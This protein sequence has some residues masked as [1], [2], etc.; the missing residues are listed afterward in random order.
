M[1]DKM[2][3][4]ALNYGK[5]EQNIHVETNLDGTVA[6]N[7]NDDLKQKISDSIIKNAPQDAG[8][9]NVRMA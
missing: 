9:H 1:R 5:G 3:W 8:V 4:H 2:V 7:E 6:N